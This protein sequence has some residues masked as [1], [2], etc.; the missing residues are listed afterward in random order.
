M[1]QVRKL[2]QGN[3]IPKAEQGYKFVLDDIERN[4]TDTQLE[5]INS[6]IL[7]IED[8]QIRQELSNW[9]PGIKSGNGFANGINNTVWEGM[10]LNDYK[11]GD[12]R[13]LREKK[14]TTGEAL[15]RKRSWYVK[16]AIN[17]GINIIREVLNESEPESSKT[18]VKNTTLDL[19]FNEKDGKKY[20]SPTAE[21]NFSARKRISD[22]LAHLQAGDSST[23]DYSEYNT[24]AISSWL[25]N[26]KWDN[27]YDSAKTYF[28]NLWANMGK[29]D[30][31]YNQD[32]EDLLRMFGINYNLKATN[33]IKVSED[34]ENKGSQYGS[35]IGDTI[36]INGKNYKITGVDSDGKFIVEEI[37]DATSNIDDVKKE[38]EENVS[39]EPIT[40][41]LNQEEI[42][43]EDN[44]SLI[45][46]NWNPEI[47]E[48]D[49]GLGIMSGLV[50]KP[51]TK[52]MELTEIGSV[53]MPFSLRISGKLLYPSGGQV[54]QRIMSDKSN[55]LFAV[56]DD[57]YIWTINPSY[58]KE[59]L[60]GKS[61]TY[62]DWS[63]NTKLFNSRVFYR[64]QGGTISKSKIE[65]F[66]N[67]FKDAIKAQEGLKLRYPHYQTK[68]VRN[69]SDGSIVGI[70]EEQDNLGNI[71]VK[72]VLLKQPTNQQEQTPLTVGNQPP[73]V[74]ETNQTSNNISNEQVSSTPEENQTIEPIKY[75]ASPRNVKPNY[76]LATLLGL[77]TNPE[78]RF[79]RMPKVGSFEFT[80]PQFKPVEQKVIKVK[81]D[82]K[83]NFND[84]VDVLEQLVGKHKEGG[85]IKAQD[86][87]VGGLV[88]NGKDYSKWLLPALS[89]ARFGINSAFQNKYYKQEL[90]ALEA[91]RYNE[92]PVTLNTPDSN[93]PTLDRALRQVNS[94]RSIRMKPVTSD[95]VANN[96][97]LNQREAQLWDRENT[98]LGQRSQYDH[99]INNEILNIQ[100][101]NNANYINTAN[102]NAAR[103]AAINSAKKQAAMELTQRRA[104]SWEN[105]GL[106]M[107]NNLY[108]D[109]Q[110]MLNYNRAME[111]QRLDKE[112]QNRFDELFP[113]ARAA[114]QSLRYDEAAKY[115]DLEDFVRQNDAYKDKYNENIDAISDLQ[116]AR[117]NGMNTW[118]YQNGLNYSYPWWF[119]GWNS[120]IGKNRYKKGGRI[121]GTTRYRLEPDEQIWVD[122]NKAVHAAIAKLSDNTIKLLLR[123]LK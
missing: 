84:L 14:A 82:Q 81:T 101:Q 97:L 93:N 90:Q 5:K 30:Y 43:P 55:T 28:D 49:T 89:L 71:T 119:T 60:S 34:D 29:D 31:K 102:Q 62:S 115:A 109:R 121:N 114:Y 98:L 6:K 59:L 46:K 26:Q 24:D 2:L 16:H 99:D 105:L 38:Q 53:N 11:R 70:I 41:E 69:N 19:D 51:Q 96:A 66:D 91:G 80:V 74:E 108:K 33:P 37:I 83:R 106:E 79:V 52:K 123:A 54:K 21:S 13:R 65:S 20:L 63:N 42:V 95:L 111:A 58:A 103:N 44:D 67:K 73:I 4:I 25:D 110:T 100:N 92:K 12:E 120:P 45:Y 72:Q 3:I 113:G 88:Q 22:I 15:F 85:I 35:K 94:E 107:Q 76:E 112:Y 8:P 56:G 61:I 86:G 10:L 27:K 116:K 47:V 75:N 118:L 64:K 23:Y 7:E 78:Y 87:S 57:G 40:E 36:V 104:Q 32:D 18:K 50:Y 39:E 117:V 122:N 9:I 1:S 68:K 48:Y 17:E 77:T